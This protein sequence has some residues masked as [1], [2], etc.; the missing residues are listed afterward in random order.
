MENAVWKSPSAPGH[1]WLPR[2]TSEIA[3]DSSLSKMHS[4]L[5]KVWGF[6]LLL[7]FFIVLRIISPVQPRLPLPVFNCL[8][9]ILSVSTLDLPQQTPTTSTSLMVT[10]LIL[11]KRHPVDLSSCPRPQ[12]TLLLLLFH[13]FYFPSK[14]WKLLLFFSNRAVSL[15]DEKNLSPSSS[16]LCFCLV[17]GQ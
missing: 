16:L 7:T 9:N 10:P 11:T 15:A 14:A 13:L 5:M 3:P 8:K 2:Q 17:I 4:A 12:I 1:L 6:T